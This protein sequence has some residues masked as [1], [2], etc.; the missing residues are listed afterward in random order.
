MDEEYKFCECG[1]GALIPVFDKKHNT[2]RKFA[3]GHGGFQKGHKVKSTEGRFE[4]GL[5][6]W[7]KGKTNPQYAFRRFLL[8]ETMI[9]CACGCGTLILPIRTDKKPKRYVN[10]HQTNTIFTA[11]GR[12]QT[13]EAKKLISIN[14]SPNSA[15]NGGKGWSLEV[16]K[17]IGEGNKRKYA[18]D[19]E[20]HISVSKRLNRY[21]LEMQKRG[22]SSLELELRDFL[23][24][25]GFKYQVG[26]F[27]TLSDFVNFELKLIIEV[28]GCFWHACPIC[29]PRN[30]LLASKIQYNAIKKDYLKRERIR[31]KGYDLIEVWEHEIKTDKKAVMNGILRTTRIKE[32]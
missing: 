9:E 22:T 20:Y 10:Y 13:E 18:N 21:N 29:F 19:K 8:M 32:R 1:C 15:W 26:L 25:L 11:K 3:Y 31:S 17:K 24:R 2:F 30:Q 16:R 7:N 28:N 6:P 27:G 12:K 23:E 4:K 5:V 14:H